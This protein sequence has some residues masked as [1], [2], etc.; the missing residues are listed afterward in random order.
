M[1][2]ITS[3][4]LG[5]SLSKL[6]TSAI[7]KAT[8]ESF[9]DRLNNTVNDWAEKLPEEYNLNPSSIFQAD[10]DDNEFLS[11]LKEKFIKKELPTKDDWQN[12]LYQQ[13]SQI[14]DKFGQDAQKFYQLE[15]T[16]VQKHLNEL[17]DEL[18]TVCQLEDDFFKKKV[19]NELDK[20]LIQIKEI[21]KESN[22]SAISSKLDSINELTK[23]IKIL[24]IF[25]PLTPL[26]TRDSNVY[27]TLH[28]IAENAILEIHKS[29]GIVCKYSDEY[30][31]TDS[32]RESKTSLINNLNDYLV[33]VDKFYQGK[34]TK[35]I[36]PTD[37]A[38]LTHGM[39]VCV[40]HW[41]NILILIKEK[42]KI[43]L[44]EE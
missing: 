3:W 33:F 43:E 9:I 19:L 4:I 17:S 20:I 18:Y 25:W 2:S 5:F 10:R 30:E 39:Q 7:E 40:N 26:L 13:W 24:N 22:N 12:A 21:T 1:F 16:I 11:I 29:Y 27:S 37:V 38:E 28:Q 32:V 44:E 23:S 6:A 42:L 41:I 8:Y 31:I 35:E 14:K 34:I 15:D 36:D